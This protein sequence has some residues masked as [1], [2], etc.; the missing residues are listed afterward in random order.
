MRK[1]LVRSISALAVAVLVAGSPTTVHAEELRGDSRTVTLSR[2]GEEAT[3]KGDGLR[4]VAVD[5]DAG[6]A[7][8]LESQYDTLHVFDI[9]AP[10]LALVAALPVSA[11]A[12]GLAVNRRTHQVFV[13]DWQ[14]NEVTVIDGDPR[15]P[16]DNQTISVLAT[17]GV[18]SF[19]LGV[20]E[21]ENQLY[22]ANS[23]SKDVTVFDLDTNARVVVATKTRPTSIAVDQVNH[24]AYV[25]SADGSLVTRVA[26]DGSFATMPMESPPG[27][28]AVAAGQ[29]LVGFTFPSAH[30]RRFN[31]VTGESTGRSEPLDSDVDGIAVDTRHQTV[32]VIHAAAG[33]PAIESLDLTSLVIDR[34][35]SVSETYLHRIA[36]DETS[37]DIYVARFTIGPLKFSRY[38]SRISPLPSVDRLGGADRYEVAAAASRD[39]FSSGAPVAYIASGQG[40]A[41]ALSGAAAAGAHGGP[42]LLVSRDGIP[43]ATAGELRRLRATKV[44]VLGGTA[45]VGSSVES[46]LRRLAGVPVVR[47][48]G[49]DRFVVSAAVSASAFPDGASV[50][51]VASGET[52]PDA[53]SAA[54]MTRTE[55][56]PVLLARKDGVP[57]PV[58]DELKRLAP[59]YLIALGGV[60]TLSQATITSMEAIAPVVRVDG[61]D[62]YA[63]SSAASKRAYP[64]LASTVFVASGEVFPD[65]LAGGPVAI[66]R[67]APVLLV[68]RDEV[69]AAVVAEL[70]R[71]KPYRIVVLGGPS[72]VSD[73]VLGELNRFLPD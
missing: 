62:R 4:G 29:L 54:P 67:R 43:P 18:W 41:D 25:S 46:E 7:Y 21:V 23:E 40:F 16:T 22:V 39:T 65:A 45:S 5:H 20:D 26:P 66:G 59:D 35:V 13:V 72:T 3:M 32:F 2:V 8:V 50:A 47:V 48:D 12:T 53:L 70:G 30:L 33:A 10:G 69:P 38:H 64:G 63:V 56:G 51:Y 15:S 36:I 44:V 11:E 17:G 28:L 27:E 37:H 58:V 42:V 68:K 55:P 73:R 1:P 24:R 19:A 31:L 71:L 57:Q 49:A 14:T 52:F 61:A 34:P 60:N 6:R 9:S